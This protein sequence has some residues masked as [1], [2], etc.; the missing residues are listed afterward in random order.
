[1]VKEKL[2]FHKPTLEDAAWAA[3]LLA[4]SGRMGC[5]YS[6]TAIYMWREMYHTRLAKEGDYLLIAVGEGDNCSFLPPVGPSLIEGVQ[7]LK[8][9][10]DGAPLRLHSVS[11]DEVKQ[12][13]AFY[14][15]RLSVRESRDDFDY[16]YAS[17]DLAN[18]PGRAYHSKKNHI[19]AFS[20]KFNWIYEAVNDDNIAEVMAM[21]KQWCAEKGTCRERGLSTERCAIRELLKNRRVLGI[22]GG[23]IRVDGAVAAFALG[24][25]INDRVF[26]IH[27][28]KALS[29]YPGAY[30]VINREFASQLTAYELLNREDDMGIEGLRKAKLSYHPAVLLKKFVCEI[31]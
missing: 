6:Y 28:E 4:S 2:L 21:A 25:P 20:K 11:E 3:P 13:T 8:E 26:D 17:E 27:V 5:E 15:G 14:G 24:S 22:Q 18:L 19:S 1:M 29:A 12:L 16:L 30:A 9:C 7:L 10:V 23:L 31:R